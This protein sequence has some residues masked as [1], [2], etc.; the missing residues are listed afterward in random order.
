[1]SHLPPFSDEANP[2]AYKAPEAEPPSEIEDQEPAQGAEAIR[3]EY[4]GHESEVRSIG[5]LYY[6]MAGFLGITSVA[7]LGLGFTLAAQDQ[8]REPGPPPLSDHLIAF[9]ILIGLMA[10]INIL[11]GLGIRRLRNWARWLVLVQTILGSGTI[12][13]GTLSQLQIEGPQVSMLGPAVILLISAYIISLL[14][15]PKSRVIFSAE[16]REVIAQTPEI[17]TGVSPT[18]KLLLFVTGALFLLAFLGGL[19]QG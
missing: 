7:M 10:M 2:Y 16:Y 4:Q 18:M 6:L 14:A 15:S 9:G 19:L 5:L 12:A 11:L 1:M 8:P 3:W 17:R 13:A